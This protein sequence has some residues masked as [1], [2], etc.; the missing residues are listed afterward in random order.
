M[1]YTKVSCTV[2]TKCASV[3]LFKLCVAG[4]A[5]NHQGPPANSQSDR[6]RSER[7]TLLVDETRFVVDPDLFRAHPNTMLGRYTRLCLLSQSQGAG[8]GH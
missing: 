7:I 8:L 4:L 5:R 1:T 2:K 6:Q 3:K